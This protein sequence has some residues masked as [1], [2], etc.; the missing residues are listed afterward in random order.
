MERRQA[1][2]RKEKINMKISHNFTCVQS[3]KSFDA[4]ISLTLFSN[5]GET[6]SHRRLAN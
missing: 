4:E 6:C 2:K 1:E 3:E 5:K